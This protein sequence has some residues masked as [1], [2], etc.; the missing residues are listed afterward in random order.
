MC[1]IIVATVTRVREVGRVVATGEKRANNDSCNNDVIMFLQSA[2]EE[3]N[4]KK[5][6]EKEKLG[7]YHL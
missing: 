7:Y 6:Q 1:V 4:K 5:I 3:K 2:S